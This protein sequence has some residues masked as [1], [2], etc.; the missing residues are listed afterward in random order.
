MTWTC[1]LYVAATPTV[2]LLKLRFWAAPT[3]AGK[4]QVR[5]QSSDK[6]EKECSETRDSLRSPGPEWQVFKV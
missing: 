4:L 6:S 2:Q 3:L 5:L 1:V